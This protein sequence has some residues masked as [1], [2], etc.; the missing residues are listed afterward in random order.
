METKIPLEDVV[1]DGG[2]GESLTDVYDMARLGKK[3]EFKV[4]TSTMPDGSLMQ[5]N[6]TMS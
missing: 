3:Q 5:V 1:A 2:W 6:G 4:R